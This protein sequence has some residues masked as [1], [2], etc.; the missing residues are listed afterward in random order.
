LAALQFATL[1]A[2]KDSRIYSSVS[3]SLA[4]ATLKTDTAIFLAIV[5]LSRSTEN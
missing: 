5:P 2:G 1:S 4:S 3:T